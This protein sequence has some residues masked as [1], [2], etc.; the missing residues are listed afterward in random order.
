MILPKYLLHLYGPIYICSYG[1]L[2]AFAIIVFSWLVLRDKRRASIITR[3]QFYD[4][5]FA[6]IVAGIVGGRTLF[7]FTNLATIDSLSSALAIWDGG[8]SILGSMIAMVPTIL[9]YTVRHAINGWALADLAALYAPILQAIGR[10]GCLSA[11]CCYGLPTQNWWGIQ[12]SDAYS[13]AP[14]GIML[15]PTQ[16]YSFALLLCSFYVLYCVIKPYA[17]RQGALVAWYFILASSERFIVDFWRGD[18]EWAAVNNVLSVHQMLAL[19]CLLGAIV[20]LTYRTK[21]GKHVPS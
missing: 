14:T 6:G 1:V 15:H 19:L 3:D 2:I 7:V 12:Y 16:L 17:Q 10:L 9:W 18:R 8:F 20:V 5:V 21:H 13:Y 11:G 4:I